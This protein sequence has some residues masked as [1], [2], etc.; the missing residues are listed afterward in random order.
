MFDVLM[1]LLSQVKP[2]DREPLIPVSMNLSSSIRAEERK[3]FEAE[4]KARTEQ[5][6]AEE[7]AAAE[8]AKVTKQLID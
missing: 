1:V 6:K 3:A 4:L 8:E 5:Q 2:S 7:E